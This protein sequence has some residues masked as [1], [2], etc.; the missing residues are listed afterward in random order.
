V[1]AIGSTARPDTGVAGR[2]LRARGLRLPAGAGR[3]GAVAPLYEADYF[4]R[5]RERMF[6]TLR[7]YYEHSSAAIGDPT[8]AVLHLR[9]ACRRWRL[10]PAEVYDIACI[11]RVRVKS[12]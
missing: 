12:R 6:A 7:A 4:R 11:E 5:G 3:A 8:V 9:A 10:G 2:G 1:I